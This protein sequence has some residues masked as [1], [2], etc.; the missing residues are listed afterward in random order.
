MRTHSQGWT[1]GTQICTVDGSKTD[2]HVK[3]HVKFDILVVI[4]ALEPL[5]CNILQILE[6][7]KIL[8][9]QFYAVV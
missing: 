3:G 1:F 5:C 8:G 6:G 7:G 2:L 4:L 9:D